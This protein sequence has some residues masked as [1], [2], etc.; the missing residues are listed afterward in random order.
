MVHHIV[1]EFIF[2]DFIPARLQYSLVSELLDVEWIIVEANTP[3]HV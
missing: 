3:L 2:A 1:Y